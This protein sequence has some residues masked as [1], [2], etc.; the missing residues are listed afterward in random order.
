ME[1]GKS[2]LNLYEVLI[3]GGD[4]FLLQLYDFYEVNNFSS[5]DLSRT[6]LMLNYC[7]N[8]DY[9]KKIIFVENAC[10]NYLLQIFDFYEVIKNY[11][12]I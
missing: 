9:H 8:D 12:T 10:Y 2:L 11:I 1:K 7:N 5:S 4:N 6:L 3:L